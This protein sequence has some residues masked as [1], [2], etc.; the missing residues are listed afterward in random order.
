MSE[1]K[2]AVTEEYTDAQRTTW[3]GAGV[4]LFLSV[5]KI[6]VGVAGNSA[7]LL[8]DGIHSL[9]DL[10]SDTL[11]LLATKHGAQPADE[12]HP[13]GHARFETAATVVLGVMLLIVAIG[14]AWDAIERSLTPGEI[15][16]PSILAIVVAMISLASNEW[17]YQ[18]T[19]A[20]AKRIHSKL[21]EAN[22]WHHRSD[23]ISSFVVLI[24]IAGAMVGHPILDAIAAFIVALMIAHIAWQLISGSV[25]ELVDTAVDDETQRQIIDLITQTDGVVSLHMLRS[26]MMGAKILVDAHLQVQP[27]LSVSE[28]HQIAETVEYLLK[29]KID[30]MQDVTIHIDPEDD[31]QAPLN[32]HLPLRTTLITQLSKEWAHI[33]AADHIK[34]IDLHYLDGRV[35]V[36]ILLPLPE[37]GVSEAREIQSAFT[38]VA[39][40]NDLLS[41][42]K[43]SYT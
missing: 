20:V 23:A 16:S 43:V 3:I 35:E 14:I 11:V 22:A 9:S 13:Y 1:D 38:A 40:K 8:A 15:L 32:S 21:L 34:E 28:G 26:R 25:K 29:N 39:E 12:D 27:R 36:E 18:Y 2:I 37:G 6:I 17:L 4:N 19:M 33:S 10:A 31:E 42:I 7:A 30:H 24:G 5:I 41:D